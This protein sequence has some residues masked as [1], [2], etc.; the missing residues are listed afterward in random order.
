MDSD[1]LTNIFKQSVEL[2]KYT[3]IGLGGTAKYFKIVKNVDELIEAVE[4]ARSL[5]MPYKLLGNGSNVLISDKF[6][7]GLVIVNKANSITVD[8]Q[9]SQIV[10]ESGASLSR[11]ILTC[12]A[13]G[14][15]GL[16]SL[17]GI[18]GTVGG[19]ICVNAGAHDV[20]IGSFLKS[21]TIMLSSEKMVNAQNEW[22]DFNYRSSRLKYKKDNFPP[23]ILSA[24]FQFQ[25]K[26]PEEI[27]RTIAKFKVWRESHQPLGQKTTGSVFKNLGSSDKNDDSP[28][29]TAGYLLDKSGAKKLKVGKIGVS[30]L[31]AN[32]IINGGEG[33]AHDARHLIEKMRDLVREKY[34][35]DLEEEIEYFG[36]WK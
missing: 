12:A 9:K 30:N 21:A 19:A 4:T 31:H 16:E 26:K 34:S 14:L 24:T 29:R 28:E 23:V 17:F 35:V 36:D 1:K 8:K 11:M 22:F 25:K 6:F 3:T 27:S 10:A 20:S 7:E 18:P 33:T 15:S 32:W 13:N 5:G 2:D